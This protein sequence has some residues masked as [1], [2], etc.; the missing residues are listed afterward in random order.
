MATVATAGVVRRALTV[1]AGSTITT[2]GRSGVTTT[3]A[4]II[5]ITTVVGRRAAAAAVA[6]RR[7]RS[8]VEVTRGS[9]VRTSGISAT[10]IS[11]QMSRLA[12]LEALSR[13][14]IHALLTGLRALAS[15]MTGSVAEEASAA[16]SS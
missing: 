2:V 15:P 6:R 5:R 11:C 14:H 10:A 7:R 8:T 4:I 13:F 1:S 9:I 16:R 12:A 3:V